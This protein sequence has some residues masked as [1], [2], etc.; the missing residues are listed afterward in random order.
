MSIVTNDD[1]AVIVFSYMDLTLKDVTTL[2][3]VCRNYKKLFDGEKLWSYFWKKKYPL[4]HEVVINYKFSY[5]QM[6][7]YEKSLKKGSNHPIEVKAS[8]IGGG[9]AGKSCLVMRFSQNIY[10][11]DY[12]PTIEDVYRKYVPHE[13]GGVL[14][15][16]IDTAGPEEYPTLREAFLRSSNYLILCYDC[17]SKPSFN[18][19]KI[20]FEESRR[21]E[22]YTVLVE[23]K[24]DAGFEEGTNHV[25][26]REARD[27]AKK[28]NM[29]FVST[30]AKDSINTSV[31]FQLI[32]DHSR[33]W[34]MIDSKILEKLNN[35]ECILYN[36]NKKKCNIS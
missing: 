23:C 16:L 24:R 12:D 14:L 11:E 6:H 17:R 7:L 13:K 33:L 28:H 10:A 4:Q 25:S 2:S 34:T 35:G 18:D 9:G 3:L 15:E 20:H 19:M 32:V 30:S 21:Y 27:F 26:Q 1:I 36:A 8:L 5:K 31:P 29:P 22:K